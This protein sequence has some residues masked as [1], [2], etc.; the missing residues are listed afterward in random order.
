M[1]LLAI[2]CKTLQNNKKE[3]PLPSHM[4]LN[5]EIRQTILSFVRKEPRTIQD[6]AL[7]IKKSWVTADRYVE[8]IIEETGLIQLKI[9]RGGTRGALKI[10]YWNY[11][12]S[13]SVSE[14]HEELYDR[15]KVGRAKTDF[16]P[17]SIFEH[18]PQEKKRA[19]SELITDTRVQHMLGLSAALKQTSES[20]L[21]FSG[22]LSW[23]QLK[24]GKTS[25]LSVVEEL[26]A[27]G[28]H[29]KIICRVDIGTR[30]NL[31]KLKP[32]LNTYGH[33]LELR[34]KSQPLRGFIRDGNFVRLKEEKK[35]SDYKESELH[36]DVRIIYEFWDDAWTQWLTQVFWNVYRKASNMESRMKELE[37]IF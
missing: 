19:Q 32:L 3:S 6:I 2:K 37:A 36:G 34:H 29:I 35:V 13:A 8:K 5:A 20:L 33:L 24:E 25:L 11:E 27:R 21:F 23:L 9:F 16:D 30:R 22:N 15:I 17:L 31:E 12:E 14:L 28:V 4:A 10:V 7:Y 18:I 26:L 1:Y